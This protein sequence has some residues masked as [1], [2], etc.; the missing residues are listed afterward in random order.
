MY[1]MLEVLIITLFLLWI[2]GL[3]RVN[4]FVL[5]DA[6][7]FSLNSVDISLWNIITLLI[8]TW[9]V[10]LLPSPFSEIAA[11]MLILWILAVLGV[12]SFT[13]M[14][15]ILML[16]ILIGLVLYLFQWREHA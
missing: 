1:K 12:F 3:I 6:Y 2:L 4:G 8:L 15:S 11:V 7:L 16:T 14:P 10:G 13:G 9:V 5:P